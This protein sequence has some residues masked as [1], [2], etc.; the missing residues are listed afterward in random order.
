MG[1]V[2]KLSNP[3]L[4]GEELREY[5]AGFWRYRIGSYLVM[6]NIKDGSDLSL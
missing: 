2:E 5:P 1:E 3:R 4:R 6:C